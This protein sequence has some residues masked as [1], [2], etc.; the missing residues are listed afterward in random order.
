MLSIVGCGGA[1]VRFAEYISSQLS[2]KPILIND[3]G[4]NINV[5]RRKVV[6]YATVDKKLVNMAFP[7]LSKINSPYIFVVAGLGGTLGTNL[8]RIMGKA[9]RSKSK[10]IGLFTLPFSS[11]NKGRIE[12]AREAIKDISRHYDMYFILDNDGLLKHYSHIQIR[13]AMNIPPEVMKH[14]IMDFKN[15]LIKNM[16]SVPISGEVGV[17]IGFGA[18]KNRLEVAI[19]DALDSPWIGKGEKI[20]LFSGNLDIEDAKVA[21]KPYNPV[22]L[23][24]FHTLEYGEEV[25]VTVIT[26]K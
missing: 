10:L 11:E 21:A 14:I 26:K 20:M 12:M 13:V 22:F 19:N 1:G 2:I 6:A 8:V 18:G 15:I 25:K 4:G 16:L 24:V 3:H 23:D 7:W 9:K 5:D 17:G